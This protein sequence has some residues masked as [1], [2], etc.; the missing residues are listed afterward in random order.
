VPDRS[1]LE[2]LMEEIRSPRTIWAP[3]GTTFTLTFVDNQE[4]KTTE[5]VF[6][7]GFDRWELRGPGDHNHLWI[8]SALGDRVP[9]PA[10][11]DVPEWWTV[12]ADVAV[13]GWLRLQSEGERRRL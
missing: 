3:D 12:L 5:E 13:D 6:D 10:D 1:D 9:N 2:E 8:F 11:D 7:F 4:A